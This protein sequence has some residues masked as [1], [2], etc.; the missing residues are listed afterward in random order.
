MTS[1]IRAAVYLLL[2]S[3]T[4]EA[5]TITNDEVGIIS[6]WGPNNGVVYGQTFVAPTAG[7]LSDATFF[8]ASTTPVDFNAFLFD[9][10]E[11]ANDVN[12]LALDQ[13]FGLATVATSEFEETTVY[14]NEA[15]LVQGEDYIVFF[16]AVGGGNA[17]NWRHGIDG[18]YPNGRFAF[19]NVPLGV[20]G[21]NWSVGRA[22]DLAFSFG[23]ADAPATTPVPIPPVAHLLV[24][25]LSALLLSAFKGRS[26]GR[27]NFSANP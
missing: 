6:A 3:T 26:E 9:W 7:G 15:P 25:A 19:R 2:M 12:G 5:L 21:D 1:S 20:G 18:N 27:K 17:A 11:S 4:A 13:V 24:G 22:G 8:I 14:F 16:E 23:F 10:N